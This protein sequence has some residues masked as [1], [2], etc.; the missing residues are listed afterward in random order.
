MSKGLCKG[1]FFSFNCFCNCFI[2][3]DVLKGHS[4]CLCINTLLFFFAVKWYSTFYLFIHRFVGTESAIR[5]ELLLYIYL[6]K[7]LFNIFFILPGKN[8]TFTFV[9]MGVSSCTWWEGSPSMGFSGLDTRIRREEKLCMEE[10]SC[11]LYLFQGLHIVS[12][13]WKFMIKMM[14]NFTDKLL[15]SVKVNQFMMS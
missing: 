15:L 12:V 14:I 6:K 11:G 13:N 4:C 2:F 8:A 1:L 7:R 3:C 9:F 5:E 10:W